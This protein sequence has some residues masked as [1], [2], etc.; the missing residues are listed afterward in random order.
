MT[1]HCAA[2]R[3]VL[4]TGRVGECYLIGSRNE[5]KNLDVVHT[6]C[7][8]LDELRPRATA[9]RTATLIEFVTDRPGHDFR[10][11]ID[12]SEDRDRARLAARQS[13]FDD[14]IRRT[15]EWYL[16]DTRVDR[17]DPVGRLPRAARARPEA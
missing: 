10:Y 15:I 1:D 3:A 12:P 16:A 8:L 5:Q 4:A 6:I 13:T 11:A 14:G 2:I 17:R 7:D 9:R